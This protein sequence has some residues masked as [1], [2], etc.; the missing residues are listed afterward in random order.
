MATVESSSVYPFKGIW[1]Y[2]DFNET[3]RLSSSPELRVNVN[4]KQRG[5]TPLYLACSKENA[6]LV[7]ILLE[8]GADPNL[9]SRGKPPLLLSVLRNHQPI[10]NL[11]L[12]YGANPNV[13]TRNVSPLHLAVSKGVIELCDILVKSGA[14][15]SLNSSQYG[16]PLHLSIRLN[17]KFVAQYLVSK[18]AK[19]QVLNSDG[20]TCLYSACRLGNQNILEIMLP[21]AMESHCRITDPENGYTLLHVSARE[22]HYKIISIIAKR[23]PSLVSVL[24]KNK[25]SV[26]FYL[27]ADN[28]KKLT[29]VF[30]KTFQKSASFGSLLNNKTYSNMEITV[31]DGT[32]LFGY[33]PI[34]SIRWKSRMGG[35]NIPDKIEISDFSGSIVKSFLFYLHADTVKIFHLEG[36][37]K[38]E[39]EKKVRLGELRD[40]ALREEVWELARLCDSLRGQG[41][42]P[43]IPKYFYKVSFQDELSQ[44][45]YSEGARHD[46]VLEV[47]EDNK[48]IKAHKAILASRCDFFKAMFDPE[49]ALKEATSDKVEIEN[50]EYSVLSAIMEYIYTFRT[51]PE[52]MM[53][54]TDLLEVRDREQEK[55]KRRKE[56]KVIG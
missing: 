40:L 33:F 1:R 50:M 29:R 36:A 14:D 31:S 15:V 11:L 55:K 37:K 26:L 28:K 54:N 3:A 20:E 30:M 51:P 32:K 41:P 17:H 34:L 10:V 2:I 44:L 43:M 23:F 7:K 53:V 56:E 12:S 5:F 52:S 47:K 48:T 21:F 19:L 9:V 49:K 45:L 13:I 39:E 42:S 46:V 4:S 27:P 25:K 35:K 6:E 38:T 18:G 8:S 24:D 16:T 22:R